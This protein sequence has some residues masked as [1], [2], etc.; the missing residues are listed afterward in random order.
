MT[1]LAPSSAVE[2][3]VGATEP[4][5]AAP[6]AARSLRVNAPTESAGTVRVAVPATFAAD[7]VRPLAAAAL[8]PRVTIASPAAATPTG[9]LAGVAGLPVKELFSLVATGVLQIAISSAMTVL[10]FAPPSPTTP[11]RALVLNGFNLVPTSPETLTALY[12][13]WSYFPGGLSMVQG[14]QQFAVVDP[15]TSDTVGNF[16]ALVTRA[17]GYNYVQLLVK[18]NDGVNVGP[19]AG[20]APPVGSVIS[21]LNIGPFGLTYTAIPTD[22][23]DLVTTKLQTPF[24]EIALPVTFDAAKG[25]A[26]RTVDNRPMDLG[27]GYSLAPADPDAET[28][29]AV[30]GF[31]PIFG[32]VQ[33]NQ[34]FSVYDSNGVAVGSF[35]GVFT[36]TAD[37][38]GI[39]TQALLVTGNDGVNVGTEAGQVPPVGSV[40]NVFY[41][42]EDDKQFVLYSSLP[43]PGGDVISLIQGANGTVTQIPITF[44]NAS[45]EPEVERLSAPGGYTFVPVSDLVPAGVNGLPPREVQ[46]QGY[47]QFD[48][49]D[50]AGNKV[51]RV[52]A[53]VTNQWDMFGIHSQAIMVTKVTE[54]TEGSGLGDAPPVGS[55]YNFVQLV[56]GR[57][58]TAH[59]TVP[60]S[61]GD[62]TKFKIVTAGREF[63]LPAI[64]HRVTQRSDVSFFSPFLTV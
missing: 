3:A 48:V 35:D 62:V 58:G 6:R 50:S 23:G 41:T 14:E 39:H 45:K 11:P 36:T 9:A 37:M 40:Y 53:D 8:S 55:I 21:T 52:D 5:P 17:L 43:A 7:S 64:R 19:G 46:V 60:T 31:L 27:N 57:L 54:G 12:G 51:G 10:N 4:V 2:T 42:T 56:N 24:G 33:G 49:F 28:L 13:R 26:D 32:A 29:T 25:V 16:D 44:I 63:E 20:Q 22:S 34:V 38:S 18:S 30:T 47:Q 59:S 15:T 61:Y 1:S